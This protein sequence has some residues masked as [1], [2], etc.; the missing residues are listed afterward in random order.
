ML[1]LRRPRDDGGLG[2]CP[3]TEYSTYDTNRANSEDGESFDCVSFKLG[4]RRTKQRGTSSMQY[5]LDDI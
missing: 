1:C 2:D 4:D 5:T 3:W